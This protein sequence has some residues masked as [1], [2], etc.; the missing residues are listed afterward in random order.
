MANPELSNT[1]I[2]RTSLPQWTSP[3]EE[4]LQNVRIAWKDFIAFS[5]PEPVRFRVS[6]CIYNRLF[7]FTYWPWF[8]QPSWKHMLVNLD[9]IPKDPGEDS[10]DV[11]NH[12]PVKCHLCKIMVDNKG[13][14]ANLYVSD[15][16]T[17]TKNASKRTDVGSL[18]ASFTRE[19]T[20]TNVWF[21]SWLCISTPNEPP[22]FSHMWLFEPQNSSP[23]HLRRRYFHH[24]SVYC[25][26]L[27]LCELW[28]GG[29]TKLVSYWLRFRN[30]ANSHFLPSTLSMTPQSLV[31]VEF[32]WTMDQTL[33]INQLCR[34]GG[35][36]KS[37]E[38]HQ[39]SFVGKIHP[40]SWNM[41]QIYGNNQSS[42]KME[43]VRKEI[44]FPHP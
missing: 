13:S 41:T 12:H 40:W 26:A 1:S 3:L 43:S 20:Q 36:L 9:H 35:T 42:I 17:P 27:R 7:K 44:C 39:Q 6:C 28:S 29:A 11:W 8:F 24:W 37:C 18:C 10:T 21:L 16:I 4:N 5:K 2:S 31:I 22:N 33:V 32:R 30:Q 38:F 34:G 23:A 14:T 19:W 25:P 15:S